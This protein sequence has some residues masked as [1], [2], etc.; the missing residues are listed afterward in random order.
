[1]NYYISVLKD[2]VTF[3]GRARRAEYWMFTLINVIICIVLYA[4]AMQ[5]ESL[6]ILYALY[7]LAVFLPS[8]AVSVRRMHDLGKSGWMV[9]I[10]LIPLIGGIILLVM[11]CMDSQPGDNEYGPNPK[12]T[13]TAA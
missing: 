11:F 5:A 10:G 13:A 6:F 8:I 1:M 2:Y 9:L 7:T 3:T 12:A 4:L